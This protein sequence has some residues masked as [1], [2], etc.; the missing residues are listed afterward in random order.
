MTAEVIPITA[1]VA[2]C[3]YCR[4]Q[5]WFIHLDGPEDSFHNVTGHE[6]AKCGYKINIKVEVIKEG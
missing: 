4:C 2:E 3:P 5:K 1:W 6:C